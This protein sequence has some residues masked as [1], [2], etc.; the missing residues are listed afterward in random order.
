MHHT[1]TYAHTGQNTD[2]KE[3]MARLALTQ[4]QYVLRYVVPS[5]TDN[6]AG[7]FSYNGVLYRAKKQR[8]G[9]KALEEQEGVNTDSRHG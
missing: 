6:H 4:W 1:R 5:V 2:G 3:K 9:K 7:Q 8:A